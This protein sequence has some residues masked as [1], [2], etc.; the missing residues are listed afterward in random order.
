VR[1][2][3]VPKAQ[4]LFP[5][6]RTGTGGVAESDLIATVSIKTLSDAVALLPN[7]ASLDPLKTDITALQATVTGLASK[8][9]LAAANAV[10]ATVESAVKKLEADA[11][12]PIALKALQDAIAKAEADITALKTKQDDHAAALQKTTTSLADLAIVVAK[13]ALDGVTGA[14]IAT[15][16]TR[17]DNLDKSKADKISLDALTKSVGDLTTALTTSATDDELKAAIAEVDKTI[18]ALEAATK[19]A[20]DIL[21][22]KIKV[23]AD[24]IA[25]NK[26]D[27]ADL[28]KKTGNVI[29]YTK[30]DT[31][32]QD[33]DHLAIFGDGVKAMAMPKLSL[34]RR[35]EV[36][37]TGIDEILLSAD[38]AEVFKKKGV[39]DRQLNLNVND[40]LGLIVG[41]VDS[42]DF[43]GNGAAPAVSGG[44][45]IEI[46]VLP[47]LRANT[48]TTFPSPTDGSV[49][50]DYSILDSAKRDIT[51]T[52]DIE[53]DGDSWK[54]RSL[55]EKTNLQFRYELG[56]KP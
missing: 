45:R 31:V 18:T 10:L 37:R 13:M 50:N 20:S 19:A 43:F 40:I 48:W 42:W 22:A 12:S 35:I 5:L 55:V 49:V 3:R 15:I 51:S 14:A 28:Q 23:N 27:I 11:S 16:Q 53:P 21:A 46:V 54:V 6:I 38:G 24:A 33:V 39:S 29:R 8:T 47:L 34:G 56:A 36:I 30:A 25:V 17:L 2:E 4:E 52:V 9:D 7:Y 26:T 1:D 32:L 41:N 44:D